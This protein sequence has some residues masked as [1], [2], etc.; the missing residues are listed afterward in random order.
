ML[1]PNVKTAAPVQAKGKPMLDNIDIHKARAEITGELTNLVYEDLA[2]LETMVQN[3]ATAED[4]QK[5]IT[6][7]DDRQQR[8]WA[9]IARYQGMGTVELEDLMYLELK[10]MYLANMALQRIAAVTAKGA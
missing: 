4:I 3:E 6:R 10:R 5:E 1:K 2:K 9:L 7:W 8:K